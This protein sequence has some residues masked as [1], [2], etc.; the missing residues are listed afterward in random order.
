MTDADTPQDKSDLGKVAKKE[1]KNRA[2]SEKKRAK[3]LLKSGQT[4]APSQQAPAASSGP[5]NSPAERSAAAAE[6]QVKLQR[7]RVFIAL[8]ALIAGLATILLQGRFTRPAAPAGEPPAPT[9][10]VP[11]QP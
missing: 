11:D 4:D 10:T 7:L 9:T 1:A 8:L 2:K 3:E 6:R 5:G